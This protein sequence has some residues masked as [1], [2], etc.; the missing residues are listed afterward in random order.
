MHE[1]Q[2]PHVGH[3][4]NRDSLTG[5]RGRADYTPAEQSFSELLLRQLH[6]VLEGKRDRLP[7]L[8]KYPGEP[9]RIGVIATPQANG[10]RPRPDIA[11]HLTW[12]A[13]D[14]VRSRALGGPISQ[15]TAD[16]GS[17]LETQDFPTKFPHIV[18]ERVDCYEA[19]NT[20][21]TDITWSLR[22]LQNQRTQT[23]INRVLDVANLLI[24]VVKFT[25]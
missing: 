5:P 14:F 2:Q 22:R 9:D 18:I 25:R 20:Q 17:I 12:A 24:E 23:R 15:R 4:V 16:D 13:I 8:R 1:N 7:L 3:R 6:E 19:G 11:E 10:D 21:P